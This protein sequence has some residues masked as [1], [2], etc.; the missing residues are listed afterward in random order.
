MGCLVLLNQEV[1]WDFV[2]CVLIQVDTVRALEIEFSEDRVVY[3]QIWRDQG[4]MVFTME[5]Q[6]KFER[7]RN[8]GRPVVSTKSIFL[9]N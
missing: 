5:W 4:D 7:G 3:V 2:T 9:L 1:D 8:A 6:L